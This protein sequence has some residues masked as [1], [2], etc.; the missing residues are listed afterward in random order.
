MEKIAIYN[1]ASEVRKFVDK[2]SKVRVIIPTLNEGKNLYEKRL[3][4]IA[5]LSPSERRNQF[6]RF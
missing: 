4:E 1:S 6:G 5:K 3:W 2:V